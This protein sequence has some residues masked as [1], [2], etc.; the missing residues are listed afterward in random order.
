MWLRGGRVHVQASRV[1]Q[2]EKRVELCSALERAATELAKERA[3]A[4]AAAREAVETA[5]A[6]RARIAAQVCA[7]V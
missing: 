4:A 3:T 2:E 6:L 5:D 7:G 1:Q